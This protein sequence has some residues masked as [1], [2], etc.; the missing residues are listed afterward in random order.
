VDDKA[1]INSE[2]LKF[3]RLMMEGTYNEN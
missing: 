1:F 3:R 2:V